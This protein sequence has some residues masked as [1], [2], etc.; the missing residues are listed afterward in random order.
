MKKYK[1]KSYSKLLI[2]REI[3]AKDINK[4]YKSLRNS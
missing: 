1:I 2:I 4:K 3:V